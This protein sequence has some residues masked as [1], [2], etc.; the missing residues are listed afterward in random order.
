M[1]FSRRSQELGRTSSPSLRCAL[2]SGVFVKLLANPRSAHLL[3]ISSKITLKIQPP[4]GGAYGDEF[5]PH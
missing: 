1:Q 2:S 4:A 5:R 3:T